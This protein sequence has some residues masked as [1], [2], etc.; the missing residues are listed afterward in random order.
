M[1]EGQREPTVQESGAVTGH[2]NVRTWARARGQD[3]SGGNRGRSGRGGGRQAGCHRQAEQA[4]GRPT[5]HRAARVSDHVL[6]GFAPFL[7]NPPNRLNCSRGRPL[8]THRQGANL[9]RWERASGSSEEPEPVP[10]TSGVSELAARPP[11]PS[12]LT[13]GPSVLPP[14]SSSSCLF[15]PCQPCMPVIARWC[16][17]RFCAVG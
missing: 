5:Q 2:P 7:W 13:D 17:S 15:T 3:G 9:Q 1:G 10:P 8:H 14:G 12:L 6:G 4:C 16:L 11:P